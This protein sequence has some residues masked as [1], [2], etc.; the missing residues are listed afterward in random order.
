MKKKII[1]GLMII[2]LGIGGYLYYQN[3]QQPVDT[4][5]PTTTLAPIT[6]GYIEK[7]IF[8]DGFVSSKEK[9][10]IDAP[11]GSS[12]S[13][14]YVT[15][16]AVVKKGDL[17]AKLDTSSLEK[18]LKSAEYA[19]QN[20]QQSLYELLNQSD[21]TTM[22]NYNKAL[23]AYNQSKT[24][25]DNNKAL[26]NA[27]I[28]TE[29]TLNNSAAS[30]DNAY[31]NYLT[32]KENVDKL[33]NSQAIDTLKTKIEI[34]QME[35]DAISFDIKAANIYAPIDGTIV[36]AYTD[37]NQSFNSGETLFEVE[38]LQKLTVEATVSEYDINMIQLDQPVK[39]EL[40]GAQTLYKGKVTYIA[41]KATNEGG[42]VVV[43]ITIDI[44]DVDESIKVNFTANIEI[45]VA[46]KKDALMVPYESLVTT[47]KGTML[48]IS[49]N[50]ETLQIP[51]EKGIVSDMFVEI[52]SDAIQEGDQIIVQ[53][54]ASQIPGNTNLRLPM[55]I[56]GGQK[57]A[58]GQKNR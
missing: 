26:Y 29:E 24:E 50:G 53:Q 22:A 11:F 56:P 12:L 10:T 36:F 5:G 14:V 42:E 45:I 35:I 25:Y 33:D 58:G 4:S 47:P 17:L 34:D 9:S 44:D 21:A 3:T 48:F 52:I 2:A 55:G 46:S 20:D 49:R 16:G 37:L 43:P 38:D 18:S 1:I 57:P 32:A 6:T 23:N 30:R 28:I 15:D 13:S 39:I 7:T 8:S 27:G 41:P 19:L 51:V 40:L 31:V 54:T